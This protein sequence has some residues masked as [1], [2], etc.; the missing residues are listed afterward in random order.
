T[1]AELSIQ[2]KDVSVTTV[3]TT[4][5]VDIPGI[6]VI[7]YDELFELE[8]QTFIVN[9]PEPDDLL[10]IMFTSGT[11]G[12]AKAVSQT[13]KNHAASHSNCQQHFDYNSDSTWLMVNPIF[14][15]SGL[16]I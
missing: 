6:K 15:I 2:L 9:N 1:P 11:T 8:T 4:S 7:Q 16:S 10:S 3:I 13:Y 12:R 14:H 5:P